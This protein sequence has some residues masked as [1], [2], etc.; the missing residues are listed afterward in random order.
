[1][2][3]WG[4][5]ADDLSAYYNDG[6]A[7]DPSNDTWTA[8]SSTTLST[9]ALVSTVW[10][11]SKIILW[12]GSQQTDG[13][14][15]DPAMDSWSAMTSSSTGRQGTPAVWTG[16]KMLVWGGSASGDSNTGDTYNP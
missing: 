4:G 5:A 6:A 2:I 7:Y 8:L 3:I 9:R 15:Y 1:M 10:T 14:I 11:G 13:K 12:A 16:S